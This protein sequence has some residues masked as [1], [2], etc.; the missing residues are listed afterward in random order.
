MAMRK[1][2]I[3]FEIGLFWVFKNLNQSSNESRVFMVF[4]EF[5]M[6]FEDEFFLR[7]GFLRFS[8]NEVKGRFE[9][10]FFLN[11]RCVEDGFF[12]RPGVF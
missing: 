10:G 3:V 8:R 7:L 9:F 2:W 4:F 1:R 5:A 12:F 11:S 6:K